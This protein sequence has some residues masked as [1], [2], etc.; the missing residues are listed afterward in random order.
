MISEAG[1]LFC[2]V[3]VFVFIAV[4][5]FVASIS[6]VDLL[7]FG[8]TAFFALL[9]VLLFIWSKFS[10]SAKEKAV[11]LETIRDVP[12]QLLETSS[13]SVRLG[14]DLDLEVPVFLPDSI[15]KRHVHIIGATGSGK[16]ESVILNL[17][18]Q[19]IKRGL[20]AI[21]LDAKGDESFVEILNSWLPHD[22][23][24]VFDL[25]S[26]ES[27]CYDPLNFGSPLEG[28]QRLFSSLIWS[29]EYYKAK[30][31]SALQR[32]F[33]SHFETHKRNPSLSEIADI[34][35]S[36]GNYAQATHVKGGYEEAAANQDYEDLAGLRD[37][38]GSL[39][40]GH[41]GAILSSG[42]ERQTLALNEVYEGRVI[43]FRLQSLLSPQ[44]VAS[45]G[46][47]LINNLN[48]LAGSAHRAAKSNSGT[49]AKQVSIFLDEF[50]SF[51]SPEFADLISKARSAGFALHFSH[52]SVGDLVEVSKGFLNRITDNSAT[53]IVMRISDPDSAEFFSRSFGTRKY[54]K[55]TQRVVNAENKGEQEVL[56]DGSQR[57]A[58]QFRAKPDLLKTHPTG[59]GS[60][61][62]AHG[63]ASKEGASH[64]FNIQFPKLIKETL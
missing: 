23:L 9:S 63:L 49:G 20:G 48:Y 27:L 42:N 2:L 14:D 3:G 15:R 57:E 56:T 4:K 60:V 55:L 35:S 25:S 6:T 41:L 38:I 11:R 7:L 46:K 33:Q 31:L 22:R 51:A 1:I 8:T 13:D 61:L 12:L 29:E 17:L 18:K 52:Q 54:Q 34:L 28:A 40:V 59:C 37:Q 53:K 10:K 30:A 45:V 64:V 47:L 26:E 19:D 39:T 58:H 21:I 5:D 16:T 24:R 32:I 43:Y 36:E 50:A 44:A 62:I